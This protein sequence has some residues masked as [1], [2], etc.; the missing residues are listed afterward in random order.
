MQKLYYGGSIITLEEENEG[1]EALLVE[2]G[3]I[4]YVGPLETAIEMSKDPEKICLN[5]RTLIP[6]FID[7]HS[8]FT[9]VA[10]SA[11]GVS[12]Q[13]AESFSDIVELLTKYISE[14]KPTKESVIFGYC[15][16]NTVLKEKK[17]P[18]KNILN[19]VSTEIPIYINHVSMHMGCANDA[20]LAICGIDQTTPDPQGGMIG[21]VEGTLEPNG[22]L[23]EIASM[24]AL[25]KLTSEIKIDPFFALTK[26]QEIYSENGITTVQDGASN[27]QIINLLKNFSSNNL[28]K[29]DVVAYPLIKDSFPEIIKQNPEYVHKYKNRLRIGGC[30]LMLDGSPQAKTAWLTK[31]YENSGDYCA[32]PI[33]KDEEVFEYTKATIDENLQVL[34]HCNGDATSDQFISNYKKALM[35]SNNPNKE[36]LRP[37]MI[38]CQTVRD[39]QLDEMVKLQMLPSIFVGHTYYW[40]DV[41]MENLGIERG[42]RIS[43]AKSALDRGLCINL[44]QD[45]PVT[46]PLMLHSMWCAVNRI[47]RSGKV[48]GPEQC[49]DV[50]DALKAV[51]IN[52]AF[53]YFEESIKGSLKAGKLA[54]LVILDKNPLTV[55][56]M[57][58]KDIRVL[59]TIK[60]GNTIW[61]LV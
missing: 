9:W 36:N 46:K 32:Y 45:S 54:D 58:I 24:Q 11:Q 28:L 48:I 19:Q 53:A 33:L 52:A 34:A 38:H 23:E 4:K 16:D 56:K 26:A 40:G 49:I 1:A 10:K 30:K 21:R 5:G 17:H 41:H 55:D 13:D 29:I 20:A 2:N 60:E 15:Y 43:P 42:R 6:A 14:N 18:T 39:D 35:Q 8:H 47:S 57:E 51:T 59:E 44:H 12:L 7:A 22:Y 31:P 25:A 27:D 37:V 61:K 50:Y 3:L